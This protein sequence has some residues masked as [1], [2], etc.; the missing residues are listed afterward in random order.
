M[1]SFADKR[2]AAV[3]AAMRDEVF[4][5][6]VKILADEGLS[7][8]TLDR[9][10]K[11][12]GVSRP[13]LYNYFPDRGGVLIYIEDRVFGKLTEK[14]D[15]IAANSTPAKQRLKSI[16]TTAIESLTRES[17]LLLAFFHQE[18]I[19]NAVLEAKAARRKRATD[20][21]SKVIEDGIEAGE[22]RPLPAGLAAEIFFG[23]ISGTIDKL[24]Y[25]GQIDPESA[26]TSEKIEILF[27]GLNK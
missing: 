10:A 12:V 21:V 25:F 3:D 4:N 7:A 5:T 2:R 14:L 17:A 24:V 19:E 22:F 18:L 8:L 13:T 16:A 11:E 1:T 15:E 23:I 6:S 26:E 20:M 9:I 27:T